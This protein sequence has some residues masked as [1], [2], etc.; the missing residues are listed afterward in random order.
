MIVDLA[1][2]KER[3]IPLPKEAFEEGIFYVC[4]SPDGKR[5]AYHWQEEIP[6]PAGVPIPIQAPGAPPPKWTAS[7][8]TVCDLDGSNSKVIVKREYNETIMGLDWR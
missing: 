6:Q 1:T 7:R 3:S 4:W 2:K 8:V 5:I